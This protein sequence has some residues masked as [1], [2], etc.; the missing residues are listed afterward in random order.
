MDWYLMVSNI[1][2]LTINLCFIHHLVRDDSMLI[3]IEVVINATVQAL[4]F[5]I[6]VVV[7]CIPFLVE[8]YS[9][10]SFSQ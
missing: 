8:S 2:V 5:G 9:S 10:R 3:E 4:F 1:T 7:S 6:I